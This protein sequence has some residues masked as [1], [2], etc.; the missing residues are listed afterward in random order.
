MK[1]ATIRL[2]GRTRAAMIDDTG[3]AHL[4]GDIS[5]VGDLMRSGLWPTITF[6]D[7]S[8]MVTADQIT[9]DQWAPP[10]RSPG[11]IICVGLNYAAHITEMGRDFPTHPTLFTKYPDALI[12]AYDDIKLPDFAFGSVDWEGEL[13]VI[14][15]TT[16]HHVDEADASQYIGGFAILND[17]TVRDFQYRTTQWLQGKSFATSCPVGPY[18][19]TPDEFKSDASLQT[20]VNGDVKQ[21]A[22]VNDLVF[23]V[24]FLVSYIS[25][26]FPLHPGDIIATGTPGGVGHSLTPTTY[27]SP[28]DKLETRI[29]SLGVQHNTVTMYNPRG[30]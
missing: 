24:D 3:N 9:P 22:T 13:A 11:K 10:V 23:S 12:G 21:N 19:V 6:S 1:F 17:L 20:L 28:G 4:I 26:F 18:M 15:G 8:H 25:Q 5:D 27:L 30:D 7:S 14:I 2:E 16:A 29:E